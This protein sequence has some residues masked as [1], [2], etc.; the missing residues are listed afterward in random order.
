M[1]HPRRYTDEQEM[2]MVSMYTDGLST[3]RIGEVFRCTSAR[4][5]KIFARR[6]VTMRDG[7]RFDFVTRK[8]IAARYSAGESTIS[9]AASLGVK[10]PTIANALKY[11]GV[12]LRDRADLARGRTGKAHP[13]YT[14]GLRCGDSYYK[15]HAPEILPDNCERCGTSD[16][17]LVHHRNGVH[18]DNRPENWER[19]CQT[20]HAK[21]HEYW[22]RRKACA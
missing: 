7:K 19:L 11:E 4:V 8:A 17:L 13:N 20:C 22:K 10:H 18:T 3:T 1:A 21:H 9:I 14:N 6:G 5:S 12:P 15:R 16:N 2:R